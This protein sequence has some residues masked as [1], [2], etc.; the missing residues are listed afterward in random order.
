VRF[1]L[2]GKSVWYG[3]PDAPAPVGT[4]TAGPTHAAAGV[5]VTV[6]VQP[7]NASYRVE[8]HYRVNGGAPAKI[9]AVLFR[10]DVRAGSQYFTARLPNLR[11]GDK[12]EYGVLCTL[13]TLQFPQPGPPHV[14]PTSFHVVGQGEAHAAAHGPPAHASGPH[15]AAAVAPHGAGASAHAGAKSAAAHA[16]SQGHGPPAH[17]GG[18]SG[19]GSNVVEGTVTSPGRGP[20]AHV[21]VEIVDKNA[22]PHVS[23][24]TATTDE[25]GHYRASYAP[26]AH[27]SK[28][29]I[30]ARAFAG[31]TL[32]GVST[33]R[34]NA[35]PHETLGVSVPAGAEGLPS[36]Y[37]SLTSAIAKVHHG[38]L[39]DLQ[40]SGEREDIT[41]LAKKLGWD[42]RA[43]VFA[44]VADR[45]AH[46]KGGHSLQAPLYYALFRAG[47][48]LEPDVLYG[49]TT[50]SVTEAWT[51]AIEAGLVPKSLAGAIDGAGKTFEALCAAHVLEQ[52]PTIGLSSLKEV[53]GVTLGHDAHRQQTFAA[54]Y[55]RYKDDQD[56]FWTNVEHAFGPDLTKRL[57]LDGQLAHLT[58]NNAPL[59]AGV[60]RAFNRPPLA[61]IGDLAW[62]G[63]H[64]ASK[65]APLLGNAIPKEIA[66]GTLDHRRAKYA[67]YLAAQVRLASPLGVVA[68]LVERGV[69]A[70]AP[71]TTPADKASMVAFFKEH[72]GRFSMGGEP[73][74]RYLAHNL[75][76]AYAPTVIAQIKRLQRVYQITPSDQAFAALLRHGLDSAYAV[77]RYDPAGFARAF[78]HDLGG[79]AVARQVHAKARV[80]AGA[81]L[82]IATARLA[83]RG[84]HAHM[85]ALTPSSGGSHG[86]HGS[87]VVSPTMEQL[88][89][90]MDF[91]DCTE[92]RSI[93]SPA[94]YLV[95]LLNF[96]DY[97]P[98]GKKNPQT[99]LLERRP[100]LQH[101]PLTCENT[102]VALP[103]IDL[104]NETLEYFVAHQLTLAD[105]H[106]HTTDGS[107]SSEELLA[108]PQFVQDS[109]YSVL[110]HAWFPPPLPFDRPLELLRLHFD[111]MGAPLHT[112][113]A[114]L[115]ARDASGHGG[116]GWTD[117]LMERVGLS[118]AEHRLLTDGALTLP[119]I[120]G[121][122]GGEGPTGAPPKPV[123][124]HTMV[125]RAH[126]NGSSSNGTAGAAPH[127]VASSS[128]VTSSAAPVASAAPLAAAA[129]VPAH[130][131]T[132][133]HAAAPPHAAAP[134]AALA[135]AH[136][137][138]P[139]AAATPAHS[140]APAPALAPAI[141]HAARSPSPDVTVL[142]ELSN[143]Q[144]FS[145]RVGIS[146]EDVAAILRTRFIN[147][148]TGLA[149]R[150][151]ALGVPFE[152]LQLLKAGGIVDSD[153]VELLPAGLD[154]VAYGAHPAAHKRDY[155][156]I[157][158]W[159]KNDANYATL[160]GLITLAKAPDADD[161][162]S[163]ATL[164][165]GY[166]NLDPARHDLRGV[167]FVRLLRFIRLW[168]KLGWSIEATDAAITA[169][170]PPAMALQGTDEA[171]D[172][173]RLD[174]GFA[175]LLSRLGFLLQ[176]IDLLSLSAEHDLPALLACWAPIG[177]D[178]RKSL[179][180]KMFG[181][182]SLLREDPV[183]AEDPSG[184]VLL[185]GAKLLE[186]EPALRS[187]LHLTG[188]ELGV[189]AAALG[190]TA[191]TPLT[192]EN[193]S[194]LYR[195]G[196]LAR[197]LRL[198]V[199]ELLALID[200]TGLDPFAPLDLE[201]AAAHAKPSS[202][203]R[204]APPA[205]R[206]VGLVQAMRDATLKPGQALYLLWNRDLSGK[207]APTDAAVT[208]L[209]RSL[210]AD[211]AA[212]ESQFALVDDPKG[213]VARGLMALVYGSD[214]TDFFFS[215]LNGTLAV[216]A[217]YAQTDAALPEAVVS[218]SQGRLAYDDL[219]KVLTCSGV[220]DDSALPA[221]NTAA[222]GNAPLL[223]ALAALS[224]ASH[225]QVDP[226]FASNK[227]L[228]APY[229]AYAASTDLAPAKR[230]ALL[231]AILPDLKW[232]K[233]EEQ[234]LATVTAAAGTDASFASALLRDAAVMASA[235]GG[236]TPAL[237]DLMAVGDPGVVKPGESRGFVE[238]PKSGFYDVAVVVDAGATVS[239]QVGG[240]AVALAHG[241]EGWTNQTPLELSAGTLV[242]VSLAVT[243]SQT[244]P[245]VKWTTTGLPWQLIPGIALYSASALDR[246]RA[247]Y[248][249]FLKAASLAAGL[250]L[251]ANEIA[252]LAA[253]EELRVE[254]T[255]WLGHLATTGPADA[256]AG[257]P[258]TA[259]LSATLDFARIKAALS[260]SDESFLAVLRNP[261]ATLAGG[262][263]A[264]QA[265]TQWDPAS[266]AA[267][268]THFFANAKTAALSH[269]SGFRR[270]YDAYAMV[271]T[272]GIS[273]A[274]LVKTTN[275]PTPADAAN[276]RSALRAQYADADWLALV[277]PINDTMRGRQRDAL[278][279]Y[280]LHHLGQRA[281]TRS[282]DTPDR[283]F[284]YLLMDVEMAPCGQTSR[285]RLALSSI[286]L[287]IERALRSLEPE[288]DP[289]HIST[290]QWEWMKR[291]RV[292]QA[293]REVFLW[294]ENWLDPELRDDPSPIFKDT[295]SDLLQGD[296]TDDSAASAM[297]AY[298][299]RLHEVAKLEPSGLFYLP[300][301]PATAGAVTHVIGRTA[302]SKRKY[303]GRRQEQ[304]S[305]T[306]WDEM[307]LGIEDD[308]VVPVLWN[309]R[310]LL[311]WLQIL[312]Q[313]PS[314]PDSSSQ[315]DDDSPPPKPKELTFDDVIHWSKADWKDYWQSVERYNAYEAKHKDK[316]DP[317]KLTDANVSDLHK[318]AKSSSGDPSVTVQAVLC[319]SEYHDGKWLGPNT[320]DVNTPAVLGTFSPHG[321][322]AFDRSKLRMRAAVLPD[323]PLLV[324]LA[325][326]SEL[327]HP[328]SGFL[329]YNTHSLPL[330]LAGIPASKL[331]A[332]SSQR[333]AAYASSA[334]RVDYRGPSS[335]TRDVLHTKMPGRVVEVQ[336]GSGDAWHAPFLYEDSRNVFFVTTEEVHQPLAASRHF[337]LVHP[338]GVGHGGTPHH[339]PPLVAPHQTPRA[340]AVAST[341]SLV[342]YDGVLIGPMGRVTST[343]S[344]VGARR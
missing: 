317:P 314:P 145:R 311:L 304:G 110:K 164:R 160:M 324:H 123:V 137:A 148:A 116:F 195:R 214:A 169:L 211:A 269:L 9:P 46:G 61:A 333:L 39:G 297:L 54:L 179:Y 254:G 308:P 230:K 142:A 242:P 140:V 184:R 262:A 274:A 157:V 212:I 114:A 342:H 171:A 43:I 172:L 256:A 167:D 151:E 236:A 292:W 112:V 36:E 15:G 295:M 326:D 255:G 223:A 27:K 103:Y 260:P 35:G 86:S 204:A 263:S 121:F 26:P 4:V 186:H 176:L 268:L 2:A 293:N 105:F 119:Q 310:L 29:D 234:T 224:K 233:R 81:A 120:Y 217:P 335:F 238:V 209:A 49:S 170:Y 243:G 78:G 57:R 174:A 250:S 52:K 283:L 210:R 281:A 321:S 276:L 37:E 289:K 96:V 82:Q 272:C 47:F 100:D 132:P 163:A 130:A 154:P 334:L 131:A 83:A 11:A 221:L 141:T 251:T 138:A 6:G 241:S 216:S 329:L 99:V 1:E 149:A 180:K 229:A 10:T 13:G 55:V 291:Y 278:V 53:L 286:Q 97:P 77:T 315:D 313:T 129:H 44:V 125:T 87:L 159:V 92:C 245:S 199:V 8:L 219:R 277:K 19:H 147:P 332:G 265:L 261:D 247:T 66:A 191:A 25:Q 198:S 165:I 88:F 126:T 316:K 258:L 139:A 257:G 193:V 144:T 232:R 33:V 41:Y 337:G 279:A 189:V 288:I 38:K 239:L 80:V 152:V 115:L 91:C 252:H 71:G 113:M 127:A 340:H 208:G 306:P 62:H 73:V 322:Q 196:W 111:A 194:A 303:F 56:A 12:V 344:H 101:L 74:E 327:D 21:L 7:L 34:Y 220:L 325:L 275:D 294:P 188:T 298:L 45:L 40:E 227:S 202:A 183:F 67:E 50:A 302:G 182:P 228:R 253:S 68:D 249:R 222:A 32:L 309:D 158:A 109:A 135:P 259:V 107:L 173:K 85:A 285:V 225:R 133:G 201:S 76:A 287:F 79:D 168:K 338:A 59:M 106:G 117:V 190:F 296:V 118:R 231:A 18:A 161:T 24:T 187:A 339:F 185:G 178:G 264:L 134:A 5:T 266:V 16:A 248:T 162:C 273:A 42:A 104:V 200:A 98:A 60:H 305:W 93:L 237:A 136:A 307:K 48:S 89:G 108:S 51:Q 328:G 246:L 94:A 206:L 280:A 284:E 65:W 156:P 102:N 218:A 226:F 192:L 318:S 235:N 75:S 95:D 330:E 244:A 213:D 197:T 320:S 319:W 177:T 301:D 23:L 343:S 290:D 20:L 205:I 181:S 312:K 30:C 90:S 28:P 14:L 166:A 331:H 175:I 64:E 271:T 341:T 323:G 240:V 22:G 146:Y 58:M 155:G 299:A 63:F 207:S 124:P 153:F 267:L 215:L 72:D 282:I 300:G 122:P 128:P 69:L 270:V 203:P 31:S 336:P 143:F 150:V 17:G 3:T 70:L 84:P